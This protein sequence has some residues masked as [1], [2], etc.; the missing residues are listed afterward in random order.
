MK[1]QQIPRVSSLSGG[2]IVAFLSFSNERLQSWDI[3][4]GLSLENS[5]ESLKKGFPALS[6]L[7]SPGVKKTR[8]KKSKRVENEPKNPKKIEK[9]SFSEVSKRGWRTEGVGA[10][11]NPS[12]TI[13]SSLFSVLFLLC[14][15]TSRSTLFWETLFA[16]FRAL[17]VSNPL[18]PTPFRNL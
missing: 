9:L 13:N 5:E 12:H 14:P 7:L 15:L 1:D 18:P 11:E 8:K 17:L 10:Q 6:L 16:V 2:A 4:R 3:V